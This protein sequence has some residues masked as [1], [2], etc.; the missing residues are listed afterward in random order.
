VKKMR[1]LLNEGETAFWVI[2][3]LIGVL[4]QVLIYTAGLE[5]FPLIPGII[6]VPVVWQLH[7]VKEGGL[8]LL[9]L[10]II[11]IGRK[12]WFGRAGLTCLILQL[13]LHRV[14]W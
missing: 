6:S 8:L 4:R 12:S 10:I 13:F 7:Y 5:Q 2:L 3:F 9:W 1:Q 14:L 11:A